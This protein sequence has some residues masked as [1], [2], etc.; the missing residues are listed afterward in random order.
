[1]P[2][3]FARIR[4]TKTEHPE[5]RDKIPLKDP[6]T[7]LWRIPPP[8]PSHPHLENFSFPYTHT[9][10]ILSALSADAYRVRR[11]ATPGRLRGNGRRCGIFFPST[12]VRGR[13]AKNNPLM[14]FALKE[15][16]LSHK[17]NGQME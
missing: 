3:C 4:E 12:P 11:A 15:K 6:K 9:N 14:D 16:R 7:P 5:P 1:M 10:K 17:A 8:P 2:S 13:T